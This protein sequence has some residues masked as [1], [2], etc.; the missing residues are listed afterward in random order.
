MP[1]E[2]DGAGG[3]LRPPRNGSRRGLREGFTTGACATAA[4]LAA[5]RALL[6]QQAV[7]TVTIHLPVGRAAS[8]GLA[9]CHFSSDSATCSVI[10]DAGDDPDVTHGAEIVASVSWL[11][12]PG[13]LELAGGPGV[14][15][16]TRPGLGLEIGGPAINPV[17]RRMI[18][19]HVQAEATAALA[20][21][22][23]RV[24]ISVPRG[25]E[26]AKKT[27]NGRLGI[28]GGI[29][30]L[31]TTGIVKPWSTASWRASV[32]Q[33]IDVAAANGQDHLVLVSGGRT[34]RYSMA[35]LSELPE[36]AFVEMGEFTGAALDRCVKAGVRRVTLA[37]MV[38]K[39]SKLAQGHFMTH[40]AGNQVDLGFLAAVA[41]EC[42]ASPDLQAQ[43][44]AANT[45]R[46]VQE[47]ALAHNLTGLFDRLAELVRARSLERVHHRLSIASLLFDADGRLLG[48]APA[49]S[50]PPARRGRSDS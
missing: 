1:M 7:A 22:G 37:G 34:E 30:I 33:A 8:F 3:E 13:R 39:F 16:V 14:G 43:I 2:D 31:G 48:R 40:V 6:R 15:T 45:A 11:A 4:A 38:G 5:T 29:S 10:K 23:L 44:G 21:R 42:G 28:L 20:T 49:D 50:S 46:H 25:E 12:E 41:A 19:E 17:P 36:L 27:L 26:L 32:L 24:E 47:L 18:T 35:L 9:R